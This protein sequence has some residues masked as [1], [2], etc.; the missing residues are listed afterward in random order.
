MSRVNVLAVMDRAVTDELPLMSAV[1][2]KEVR[3]A[4]AELIDAAELLLLLP[5]ADERLNILKKAI[6]TKTEDSAWI[7]LE[8]ALSRV[9]GAE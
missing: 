1:D 6:G 5:I 9:R 7:K 8:S 3:A 2:M 4:V